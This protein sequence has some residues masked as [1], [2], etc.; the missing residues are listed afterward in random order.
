MRSGGE[1]A[2]T[3]RTC[4]RELIETESVR[5]CCHVPRPVHYGE[6]R[7]GV[8][9]AYAGAVRDDGADVEVE[10]DGGIG[11]TEH[12]G[13]WG[14][15]EE[16]DRFAVGRAILGVGEPAPVGHIRGQRGVSR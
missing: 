1:E 15:V 8:G 13:A 7:L 14:T 10:R 3:R 16:E 5:Q 2:S 4:N 11:V 12:A 6:A 9:Q